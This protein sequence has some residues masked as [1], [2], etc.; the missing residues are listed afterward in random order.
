MADVHDE[1][2][3]RRNMSAIRGKNTK[4]EIT[5]RKELFRRGFRFRLHRKDLPGKPDIVLPKYHA[6]I[7]VQGCFW[8]GHNGCPLF[9][10]PSSRQDF[11][12]NKINSNKTRDA[13]NTRKLLESGWRIC[14]IWECSMK[15]KGRKPLEDVMSELSEW[16]RGDRLYAEIHG[17]NIVTPPVL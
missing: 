9:K 10:L 17:K 8:H 11:W 14:E 16:L 5:L 3:R 2:T 12:L 6:V 1:A 4:P 15:G 13:E 7:Q